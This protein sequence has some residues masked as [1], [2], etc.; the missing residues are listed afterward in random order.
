LVIRHFIEKIKLTSQYDQPTNV[1]DVN[2]G[3]F[4][5]TRNIVLF[6]P[7]NELV[8]KLVENALELMTL[9]NPGFR[10]TGIYKSKAIKMYL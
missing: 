7:N 4:N 5:Q 2:L 10:P 3:A 9:S 1:L 8:R 6:Y